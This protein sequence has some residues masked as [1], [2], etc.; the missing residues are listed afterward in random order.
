MIHGNR[1]LHRSGCSPGPLEATSF[2]GEGVLE[3]EPKRSG[4][5]GGEER[6]VP[7]AEIKMDQQS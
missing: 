6:A 2:V 1:N 5:R 3:G 4:R 7:A